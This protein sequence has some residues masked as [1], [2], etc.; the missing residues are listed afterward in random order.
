MKYSEPKTK[1]QVKTL[2]RD[3]NVF[4]DHFLRGVA[5]LRVDGDIGPATRKRVKFVKYYLGFTKPRT[6]HVGIAF[7]RRLD[8]PFSPLAY[9]GVKQTARGVK[10]RHAQRRAARRHEREA[11]RTEGVGHFDGRAVANWLIP[12]LTWARAHDWNGTLSSGWRDPVYS[13]HL[14]YVMCGAPSCP[15]RCAG[16]SSNH[17]GSSKPHGAVDVTYYSDFARIIARC[18]LEPKIYNALGTRDPVHFSATGR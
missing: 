7:L 17:S 2:Q 18:P 12:Y 13:E 4:V 3:L 10:R 15:G 14:C 16:R 6:S 9:G 5:R 8:H 1:S 11:H